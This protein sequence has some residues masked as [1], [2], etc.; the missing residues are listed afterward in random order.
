[1]L[2]RH[3]LRAPPR[4]HRARRDRR[5]RSTSSPCRAAR[6]ALRARTRAAAATRLPSLGRRPRAGGAD[7]RRP[8]SRS[9]SAGSIVTPRRP[10][11]STIARRSPSATSGPKQDQGAQGVPLQLAHVLE[12]PEKSLRSVTTTRTVRT[13]SRERGH[14]GEERLALGCGRECPDLLELVNHEQKARP[15]SAQLAREPSG[16]RLELRERVPLAHAEERCHGSRER[17][18]GL[19]S[20]HDDGR[21][22]LGPRAERSPLDPRHDPRTNERRLARPRRPRD[23]DERIGA[24]LGHHGRG[25]GFATEE[26]RA[27]LGPERK[28]PA[29]RVLARVVERIGGVH[30]ACVRSGDARERVAQLVGCRARPRVE[31]QAA[32]DEL[33]E[34]RRGAGASCREVAEAPDEHARAHLRQSHLEAGGEPR[35]AGGPPARSSKR[36][37][38]ERVDVGRGGR[39]LSAPGLGSHVERRPRDVLA[40]GRPRR[41]ASSAPRRA[42]RVGAG[43]G[44]ACRAPA[45]A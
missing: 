8:I 40:Q 37:A 14:D 21:L 19:P 16:R 20:R 4:H 45:S 18:G 10:A 38:P 13:R 35:D 2:R 11:G 28:Q 26:E 24:K 42:L 3:G 22:P 43:G 29:V 32:G 25:L 17:L 15:G 30:G 1:M 23:E 12:V 36:S 27:V 31:A 44:V 7:T 39:R 33:H 9:T 6:T 5:R 34:R 41:V